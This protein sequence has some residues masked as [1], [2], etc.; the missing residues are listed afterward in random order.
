ME[1]YAGRLEGEPLTFDQ[2]VPIEVTLDVTFTPEE[3]WN[4]IG[5]RVDV[6]GELRFERSMHMR[7]LFRDPHRSMGRPRSLT[8]RARF[9]SPAARVPIPRPIVSRLTGHDPWMSVRVVDAE[10]HVVRGA[11]ARGAGQ[12]RVMKPLVPGAHAVERTSASSPWI[13]VLCLSTLVFDQA[14]LASRPCELPCRPPR[15]MM[16]TSLRRDGRS[17]S[18][19]VT[20]TQTQSV[21]HVIG[22]YYAAIGGYEALKAV[23]T[24]RMR[25]TYT[26]GRL[27]ATTDIAWE[28]PAL[29]RVNV[30]AP[31]FEY[32]EGFDG[33]T[34]EY[35]SQARSFIR[36]SGAAADAG[37]RG[38]EF[39]ESFVDHRAKGHR[40]TF[41][42]VDSL[43]R[44]KPSTCTLPS[45]MDR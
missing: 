39:D 15:R 29:R 36:P 42:G 17:R 11:P 4:G 44:G 16:P 14:R 43:W 2:Y 28:R 27:R 3:L 25:G 35:D 21:D 40:V 6:A 22:M 37:R 38:A 30:H 9:W 34:W 45:K 41:V 20:P 32:S 23:Q 18:M 10:G 7:L 19:I 1:R 24:R 5:A 12:Q 31:G 26:E 13:V 8:V 33:S